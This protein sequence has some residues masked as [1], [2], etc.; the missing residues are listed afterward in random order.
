MLNFKFFSFMETFL[1]ILI[2]GLHQHNRQRL[3]PVRKIIR[4]TG[5]WHIGRQFAL[6]L[7]LIRLKI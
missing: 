4:L 5:V 3:F 6:N 2:F 1:D 7:K